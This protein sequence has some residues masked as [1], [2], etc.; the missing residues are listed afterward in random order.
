MRTPNQRNRYAKL[1]GRLNK[2][3]L[4]VQNIYDLLNVE[5][6]RIATGT[7]FVGGGVFRFSD[8]PMTADAVNKLQERFVREMRG[9]IYSGTSA[10]WKESNLVQDLLANDVLRSYGATIR[11]QKTQVYYQKNSDA[12]RAFQERTEREMNLST[13]LWNQSGN[14]K[15]EL[16]YAIS[17]AI[18]KGTSAVTLSKRLSKYLHD[19]PSLKADYK[20]KFGQAVTCQD[21]EY[22]SIRLARTE[23]NMAYRTAEQ[24]RW[25]QMDFVVGYEVK[26]SFSH[27][28]TD[29][30]DSA[31]GK[32]P[33]D[34]VFMGWHPNCMCYTIPILKTEQEFW[35][36]DTSAPSVNEV[37][38]V[39]TGFKQ[40]VQDNQ[41]RLAV[42][43]QRGT[44]PYWYSDNIGY[45][46]ST[47]NQQVAQEA[48]KMS[49][50]DADELIMRGFRRRKFIGAQNYNNSDMAGFD[51]LTFDRQFEGICDEFGIRL[52]SKELED[53]L[54]GKVFLNYK[55]RL[56]DMPEKEVELTRYFRH[57]MIG[58]EKAKVVYHQLFVLPEEVQGKGIS[59]RVTKALVEQYE[60]AGIKRAYIHANITE[61]GLCWAK[62][63]ALAEKNTIQ[64][65]G[66]NALAEGKITAEEF[67]HLTSY[68]SK[69]GE[70]VPMQDIAYSSY[71]ERLL[72][73]SSW[74]GYLDFADKGQ[75]EYLRRYIG[76]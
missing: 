36:E 21:C 58:G 33:K 27:E 35:S 49:E 43:E 47:E 32:Y 15:Q 73:G 55:G 11:G 69:F 37:T 75:M 13:K 74:H 48:W 53:A 51:M 1:K 76:M 60:R 54:D 22:R 9:L 61:G 38:D 14:Y 23:I 5:A 66:E 6:A 68:L 63:G 42:A 34:F 72:R 12:L 4:A 40:W 65:I 17:S 29:I 19:F 70:S 7:G 3:S 71:G 52:R 26:L 44:L 8:Y 18:E 62:Y 45:V 31:Q 2:Y 46:G 16:E 24:K 64:V 39:P 59:K 25:Q 50:N 10:E 30:C 57:E 67:K 28:V 41:E 56:G 20:E